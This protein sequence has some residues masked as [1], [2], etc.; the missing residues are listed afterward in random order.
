V[1]RAVERDGFDWAQRLR[2]TPSNHGLKS[3]AIP[4]GPTRRAHGEK[5]PVA[6]SRRDTTDSPDPPQGAG[7]DCKSMIQGLVS[8]DRNIVTQQFQGEVRFLTTQKQGK[9]RFHC[10]VVAGC[11]DA[12]HRPD[13]AVAVQR[14][15]NLPG[16]KLRAAVSLGRGQCCRKRQPRLVCPVRTPTG[17]SAPTRRADR[18][19]RRCVSART[20]SSYTRAPARTRGGGGRS[21]GSEPCHAATAKEWPGRRLGTPAG[22]P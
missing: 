18:G 11:A 20:I 8:G 21:D 15:L 22:T 5:R 3:L 2:V 16:S 10:G 4:E 7:R 14:A 17:R 1:V 19:P 12:A 6:H 9:E 13:Q